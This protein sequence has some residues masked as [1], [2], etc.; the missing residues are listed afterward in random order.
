MIIILTI[1][2]KINFKGNKGSKNKQHSHDKVKT[3]YKSDNKHY[4]LFKL[5]NFKQILL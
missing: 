3:K 5:D 1:R 2:K 4:N